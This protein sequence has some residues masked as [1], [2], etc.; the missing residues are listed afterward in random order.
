MDR[1]EKR[2]QP[3]PRKPSF[4]ST[5]LDAISISKTHVK[6]ERE[7]TMMRKKQSISSISQFADGF[8]QLQRNAKKTTETATVST[9]PKPIRTGSLGSS[10]AELTQQKKTQL[11]EIQIPKGSY[12]YHLPRQRQQQQQKKMTSTPK[13]PFSPGGRLLSFFNSLFATSAS[14][15]KANGSTPDRRPKLNR[16]SSTTLS[17]CLSK[18][19]S[20]RGNSLKPVRFC[21][22]S[23]VF[24]EDCRPC[25]EKR[26]D[27]REGNLGH[28]PLTF[29]MEKTRRVEE[30]AR[31]LSY[32]YRKKM[33][34]LGEVRRDH[35][36][37]EDDCDDGESCSSSDLFELENLALI[38]SR[39]RYGEELPVY[40]TTSLDSNRPLLGV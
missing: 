7:Q 10:R 29:L 38:G 4:P 37:V 14:A 17:S 23:V 15:K 32:G 9:R 25:S 11:P 39:D 6:R 16:S 19:P 21:P 2:Y 36:L 1:Y 12:G 3:K 20:A 30:A 18:T 35:L 40:E 13:Q 22:V 24:D 34:F 27:E 5:L 26:L 33:E 28:Q 8:Q 31:E